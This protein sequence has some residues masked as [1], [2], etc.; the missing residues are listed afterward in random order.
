MPARVA[1]CRAF[2]HNRS[3]RKDVSRM[4]L[5]T[6]IA[7]RIRSASPWGRRLLPWRRPGMHHRA[8]ELCAGTVAAGRARRAQAP[9]RREPPPEPDPRVSGDAGPSRGLVALHRRDGQSARGDGRGHR[10]TVPPLGLRRVRRR[11][12]RLAR[13]TRP[14]PPRR[15]LPA[16]GAR[17]HSSGD[18]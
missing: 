9:D 11:G 14:R 7:G 16:R 4:S 13:W 2:R 12:R 18:F 17:S 15:S 3:K 8:G 6:S 10:R 5:K 1:I